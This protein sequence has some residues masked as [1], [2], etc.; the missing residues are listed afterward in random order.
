MYLAKKEMFKNIKQKDIAEKV[1][2]TEWTL[3]RI[4]NNKQLTKKTT[5]YCIAK[6]INNNA[7]IKDFFEEKGE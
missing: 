5:A 2:I 4:I 7:E 1:G 3:S 6:A